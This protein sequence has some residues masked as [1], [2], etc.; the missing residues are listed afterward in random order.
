MQKKNMNTDPRI[1][2]VLEKVRP[3][4][5]QCIQQANLLFHQIVER[6][7]IFVLRT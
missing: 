3:I 7:N 6:I 2:L 5:N 4:R 1:V